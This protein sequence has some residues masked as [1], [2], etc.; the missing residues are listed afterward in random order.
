MDAW[1]LT[2]QRYTA[3][4]L[5]GEGARRYGGRW[6]SK[7][8]PAIYASSTLS[9]AVL[10]VLV[11]VDSSDAPE[12]YVAVKLRIPDEATES[13]SSSQLPSHWRAFPSPQALRRIGDAWLTANRGLALRVP[14]AL[15]PEECNVMLNPQHPAMT[16]VAILE[17]KPFHFDPRLFE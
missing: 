1:R 8:V 5:A 4:P 9:L 3:A 11:H 7:G 12:D 2:R 17:A 16:S 6:N 15:I 14:S 10:E 13:L